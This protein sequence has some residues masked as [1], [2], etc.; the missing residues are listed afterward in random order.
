MDQLPWVPVP[1]R[2]VPVR[3]TLPWRTLCSENIHNAKIII[4]INIP[5]KGI[6]RKY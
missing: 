3:L 6:F 2:R 1:L 5:K 4:I